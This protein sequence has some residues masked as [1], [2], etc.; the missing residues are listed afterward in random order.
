[1]N[2]EWEEAV[3]GCLG[4]LAIE[5]GE[6]RLNDTLAAALGNDRRKMDRFFERLSGRDF[7]EAVW[8]AHGIARDWDGA[9]EFCT[10][11]RTEIE[12]NKSKM[13]A[14]MS[15]A[16]AV[17]S[18]FV[19]PIAPSFLD[20]LTQSV[21]YGGTTGAVNGSSRVAPCLREM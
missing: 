19:R 12:S 4:Y 14:G 17:K 2:P 20:C 18:P 8:R 3:E 11:L 6:A 16:N 10:A 1:M 7:E 15:T 5:K 13:Q 21:I 9:K